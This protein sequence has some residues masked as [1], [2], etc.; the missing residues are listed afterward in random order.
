[1]EVTP[2]QGQYDVR[3]PRTGL[4]R[5]LADQGIRVG[6]NLV[7]DF[8][9]TRV[10][11]PARVGRMLVAYPPIPVVAVSEQ[12]SA[13]V[14]GARAVRLPFPSTVT[15]REPRGSR[16][17]ELFRSSP[18]SWAVQR[19]FD[20]SPHQ[21]WRAEGPSGPHLLGAVVERVDPPGGRIAIVGNA[22]FVEDQYLE[23]DDNVQLV[24][25]LVEWLGGHRA[26]TQMVSDERA[27]AAEAEGAPRSRTP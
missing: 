15:V 27:R 24:R 9:C 8:Q 6:Q 18:Q 4:E 3:V 1:M 16:V 21:R 7:F 11:V 19:R 14:P 22:R 12:A 13:I 20:L 5:L 23:Y 2:G 26:L 10:S 17:T 25:E